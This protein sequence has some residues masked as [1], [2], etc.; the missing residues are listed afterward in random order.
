MVSSGLGL[1]LAQTFL[2]Q[3]MGVIEC[4]RRPGCIDFSILILLP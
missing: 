1:T 4:E 3:H 2:Q